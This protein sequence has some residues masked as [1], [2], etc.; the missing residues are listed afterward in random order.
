MTSS[1]LASAAV[2][3]CQ[4]LKDPGCTAD[5]PTE[6]YWKPG[7]TMRLHA[8]AGVEICICIMSLRQLTEF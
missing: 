4:Y 5:P 6:K 1:M 7:D 8:H 2:T 3:H